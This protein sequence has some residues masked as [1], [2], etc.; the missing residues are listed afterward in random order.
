VFGSNETRPNPT[1]ICIANTC[2]SV[3]FGALLLPVVGIMHAFALS[4][5]LSNGMTLQTVHPVGAW[6]V[7]IRLLILA[8]GRDD[9][10]GREGLAHYVEHLIAS[11]PGPLE[12]GSEGKLR[13]SAHGDANAYTWPTATVFSMDVSPESLESALSLLAERLSHLAASDAM[14]ARERGIVLQEFSLRFGNDPGAR[15]IAGLRTKLGQTVPTFGWNLGTP[16]SIKTLDL[17]SARTFFD[18]WYRSENMTLVLSGPID[19]ETVREVAERTVGLI[20]SRPALPRDAGPARPVPAPVV[21][22]RDDPDAAVLM[23]LRHLLIQAVQ[24]TPEDMMKEHAAMLALQALLVGVKEGPK[25]LLARLTDSHKD[26]RA[27][28]AGLTRL[29][30]GWLLLGISVE[31]DPAASRTE[32]V[33]LVT[34]RLATFAGRDVPDQLLSD[35]HD[36]ADRTWL[37][38]ESAPGADDVVEWLRQGFRLQERSH[39]RAA[40]MS[41]TRKDIVAFAHKIATPTTSATVL[42]QPAK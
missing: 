7:G 41:L 18:H 16:D 8:G 9:P 25:S 6:R 19:L 34:H 35:F 3:V 10:R 15:L 31:A 30:R 4:E 5:K 38:A 42:L 37:V 40:L 2:A 21:V 14:A 32:M 28:A 39:L 1:R 12:P 13:L 24:R 29:D 17:A 11:D 33:G 23:V 36:A 26:V 22:E 20:P 27:V